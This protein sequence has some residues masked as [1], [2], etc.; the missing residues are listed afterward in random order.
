MSLNNTEGWIRT[1]L[2]KPRIGGRGWAS[3]LSNGFPSSCS[4]RIEVR[5]HP[6]AGGSM[7]LGRGAAGKRTINGWFE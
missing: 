6:R 7:F 5:L 4:N 3:T 2:A 1:E